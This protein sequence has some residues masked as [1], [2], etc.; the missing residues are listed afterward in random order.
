MI[1]PQPKPVVILT[2]EDIQKPQVQNVVHFVEK[3][4]K[5]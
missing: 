3:T 1:K 5:V 4:V 2:P